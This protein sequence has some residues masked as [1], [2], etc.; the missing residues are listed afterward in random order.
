[1]IRGKESSR[2]LLNNF[3]QIIFKDSVRTSQG[4][5]GGGGGGTGVMR[6]RSI[7]ISPTGP[8]T[9]YECAGEDQH[10]FT[11]TLSNPN[12]QETHYGSIIETNL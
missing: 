10:H 11:T 2:F 6:Q 7:V 12:S 1:M 9:K 5:E 8:E 4:T 3:F